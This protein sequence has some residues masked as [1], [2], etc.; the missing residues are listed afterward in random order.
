MGNTIIS[1][2]ATSWGGG[3][4]ISASAA[5]IISNIIQGNQAT[6]GGGLYVWLSS[7]QLY[8]NIIRDN[9]AVQTGGGVY[10]QW[11]FPTLANNVIVANHVEN[12]NSDK[13]NGLHIEGANPTMSHNTI[14][15]N[16]GGDDKGSGVFIVDLEEWGQ[17]T[18]Y[19]TN[20]ILADQPVGIFANGVSTLTVNGV[21]WHNTPITIT[22]S[23]TAVLSVIQQHSGDPDFAIDGYHLTSGSAAID[24]GLDAN[25]SVDIDGD[26]RPNG[27]GYDLGADEFY[28]YDLSVTLDGTGVGS[29]SSTP[30]GI[31]CTADPA[32]DCTES[33][34]LGTTV[35]L[36]ATADPGS[37]FTGW[38]GE[39]S[40]DGDCVITMTENKAVTA[41]FDMIAIYLPLISR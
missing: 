36:T 35:T 23:P 17:P 39:C 31:A 5:H 29:V 6:I 25:T 37:T 38:G 4:E 18:V 11:G 12:T 2:T 26:P 15:R 41:T 33:F 30:A 21:L 40:G 13:G 9:A 27:T 20:T 22:T 34:D 16:T 32:S 14:A 10:F 1:N 19:M 8:Q 7:P 24:K 28:L 3:L